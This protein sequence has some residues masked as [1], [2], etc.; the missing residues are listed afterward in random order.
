MPSVYHGL[1]PKHVMY[2]TG[3]YHRRAGMS[4]TSLA[5]QAA[6][7]A[8]YGAHAGQEHMIPDTGEPAAGQT[9]QPKG[10]AAAAPP[11]GG[12]PGP[13]DWQ[14]LLGSLI[15]GGLGIPG[16]PGGGGASAAVPGMGPQPVYQGSSPGGALPEQAPVQYTPGPMPG[17]VVPPRPAAPPGTLVVTTPWY[18]KWWVLLLGAVAAAVAG[19]Y[20]VRYYQHRGHGHALAAH[21]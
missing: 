16:L 21:K 19:Y 9:A 7:A 3:R 18:K 4:T 8:M 20:G 1:V 14:G 11:G 15:P 13:M 5:Q 12:P 6:L 2:A 17:P 10:G